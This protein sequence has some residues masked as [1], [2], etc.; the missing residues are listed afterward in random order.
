MIAG[1]TRCLALIAGD[2]RLP[3][4]VAR[5][6]RAR[7]RKVLALALEG[8]TDPALEREVEQIHW[9]HV[10]EFERM[11]AILSQAGVR[12]A[13]MAGKVS[14]QLLYGRPELL[15]PDESALRLLAGLTDRRDESILAGLAD[16][17]ARADVELRPQSEWI[18]A[19]FFPPGPLGACAPAV[20]QRRDISIGWPIAKGMAEQGIGQTL[21]VE[22]GA[23]L[24]VEAIE[25]T[26]AALRRGGRLGG[27]RSCA[28]KV[29]RSDPDRRFD[30]PAIGLGTLEAM[31]EAGI[32]ALAFEASC[33]IILDRDELVAR[34]DSRGIPLVGIGAG[35]P[36]WERRIDR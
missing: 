11:L 19:L 5:G 14:K 8:L 16:L 28:I 26:D 18:P 23:V 13:V 6:A 25:G 33:T 24:A 17:L 36:D 1:P 7:G 29:A 31:E 3:I 27:G 21:V 22:A 30:L 35:G 34:A 20:H 2:G 15:R 9:L 12:E 10:G 4:E 32:G